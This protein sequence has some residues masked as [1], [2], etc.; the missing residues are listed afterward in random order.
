M[1]IEHID[2][3]VL[4]AGA[5][6]SLALAVALAAALREAGAWLPATLER[7]HAAAVRPPVAPDTQCSICLE[8]PPTLATETLCGHTFC[9][10]CF[11][12]HCRA[13][14][15]GLHPARCPLCRGQVTLLVERFQEGETNHAQRA[16]RELS[17]YNGLS[18]PQGRVWNLARETPRLLARL[19]RYPSHV[20]VLLRIGRVLV[21]FVLT[22]LY[23]LSPFDFVPEAAFGAVGL[24]DDAAVLAIALVQVAIVYRRLLE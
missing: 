10:E 7:Q 1:L 9:A 4:I 23:L 2:D 21:G 16:R 17:A 6:F 8:E 11:L 18:S 22:V 24:L 13:S 5:I 15:Q 12:A 3:D 14:T 20:L 19:W